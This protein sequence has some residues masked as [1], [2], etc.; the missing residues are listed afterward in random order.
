MQNVAT[1]NSVSKQKVRRMLRQAKNK[2]KN[3]S[4]KIAQFL[5][6][7]K[8][9]NQPLHTT[10]FITTSGLH[11]RSH[12][13]EKN[14]QNTPPEHHQTKFHRRL[15]SSFMLGWNQNL[16]FFRPC[17]SQ[18]RFFGRKSGL[19]TRKR[20]QTHCKRWWWSVRLC[21]LVLFLCVSCS[22]PII[23]E[24]AV[25]KKKKKNLWV[26]SENGLNSL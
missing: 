13:G 17:T 24:L 7:N 12:H 26:L 16:R 21:C 11:E 9:R 25:E 6:V 5:G 8:F 22:E 23:Q 19:Y 3:N 10:R 20:P 4:S 2:P 14:P 1:E 18:A 15:G